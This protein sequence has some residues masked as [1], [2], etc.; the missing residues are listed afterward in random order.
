MFTR[1]CLKGFFAMLFCLTLLGQSGYGQIGTAAVSGVV[2]D[3]S[4]AAV[5]GAT[6][7]LVS[8]D[9]GYSHSAVTNSAGAYEFPDLHPGPY[10]ITANAA[11]FK[12]QLVTNLVLYVGIAGVQN[13]AFEV[14]ATSEQV[15]VSASAPLLRLDSAEVGTVIEGKALTDIP[16]NGRNFLQLNLLTPGA[17]RSK[18]GNT[19]DGVVID[20][21]AQSFNVNG[22][23]GDY[24][25]YLLDG[26]TIKEYQHGSNTLSPSVEAIQ[27]FNVA[28]SNY[29]AAFGSE[30][31]AQVNLLTKAGTNQIHGNAFEFLRN[32]DLDA[33]NFFE[34]SHI[35]PPF[36][37]N[38]FGG[39]IGGP[40]IIPA[41]YH[42]QNKTFWFFS[43]QGMRQAL[44]APL[45]G[46]FPTPTELTGNLSDLVGPDGPPVI[47][48]VTGNPFPGNQ[49][50]QNRIP[51]TLLPFLQNGIGNGPWLPVPNY[52]GIPGLNYFKDDSTRYSGDQIITRVDQRISDKTYLYG[53]F[54]YNNENLT[55]PNLNSNFN[56]YQKNHTET[57]A[58]HLSHTFTSNLIGEVSV[59]LSQ[60]IQNEEAT[61]IFKDDITNKILQIRGLSTIPD[62]WGAPGWEPSGYSELGE[63]GS[64]PRLW[65]PTIF[66]VRPSF[67]WN[68]GKHQMRFGGEF[69]RF[70]DTFQEII[71]PNGD[72][73]YNGSFTNYSL[74]DFLLGIPSSTL[75]SP[76]PFNPRQRYSEI[77]EYFQDD[78][79]I[80]HN[81]TLNLGLRYEWSGVPYSS[82]R[83][84]SNIY[85][86][87]DGSAPL[88][89]T[90]KNVQGIDFEG[91]R[92]PLLTIAP[93]QTAESVGLPDSL[94]FNDKKDLGP[95]LGFAYS[96]T[97]LRNT[98]IRGGYG[99]FYQRDTE[100]RYIDMALNPPF[101]SI[102][103]F[104]FDHTNFQQFDWF[105]PAAQENTSGVG[106]FGNAP[107]ARNGRIQAYNLTFEHTFGSTLL[108]AAYVGNNSVHL[109]NLTQ[110]NQAQ[111]GPGSFISRQRWPGAGQV[112]IQGYDGIGNYNSL[113]L[114]AQKNFSKGF[115]LLASYTWSKTLDDTGGT[116]TGEGDRGST[117]ED[118]Y[119]ERNHDYGLAAQDIRQRLVV[120]YI[121]ELPFGHGKALLNQSR[122]ADAVVGG[123]SVN[124]VTALQ[125]G[126]PVPMYQTC[127]RANTDAGNARPDVVGDWHLSSGRADI[128]KVREYFNTAAFVNVCPDLSGPGP[129]SFSHTGRNFV[130]GP[131]V[132]DWDFAVSRRFRLSGEST[133]LQF[134]AEFFNLFNH[135]NLGQP[136][137]Y[138]GDPGF[139]TIAY[140]ATD[141]REIQFG[142]K[143]NF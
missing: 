67:E 86:P 114:K 129:F 73:S 82:N 115:M 109:G 108:S 28:T 77:G 53:R 85:L 42:G 9:Q 24:N 117:F 135:P 62:S 107:Q 10:K 17:T 87:P 11:G 138:A 119:D 72:F 106:L 15:S 95:R 123:W 31:G 61:T 84:M 80:T 51:S 3:P 131:G 83:T 16:L 120:S 60:F 99:I 55:D 45:F 38:Q 49:I 122:L 93:Y 92:H 39:T 7:T 23:H 132:Q 2:T 130:I 1:S 57:G 110:P 96:P 75:F 13:F 91:V 14:G 112:N 116:F 18:D 137:A 140:T 142:L 50:P 88:I 35:T 65:K 94:I 32:N 103:S 22:Q 64:L 102:R 52:T 41:V 126:S 66:E 121:Y 36:R 59:G 79:K 97:A 58:L 90:S 44:T 136:D 69:M 26:T 34:P 4:G 139:G 25:V 105:N 134:R 78:W 104:A 29:S 141:A 124:G 6:I 43:Y 111:P 68:R 100:N 133:W 20:P 21:T 12:T 30:A 8:E 33:S 56:F 127:N 101:V 98:V 71:E 125:S 143:L 128:E 74:G 48:P 37:R 47:D 63:G 40:L 27:E 76:E 89:V 113:Q 118:S 70:L 54:A 46:Y 81:L 19:F 5:A